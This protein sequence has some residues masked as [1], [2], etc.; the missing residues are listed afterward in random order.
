M[1]AMGI[2]PSTATPPSD[3]RAPDLGI[4]DGLVQLSN[5]VQAVLAEGGPRGARS[6]LAEVGT[7]ADLSLLQGRLLG[8]LRDRQPSMAELARL[9]GLDKSSTT[10]LV[11]RAERRGL[12]RRVEVPE[13]GRSFRV[14]LTEEGGRLAEVLGAEV[15]R[16]VAAITEGLSDTNRHRL[17]LLA[18]RVVIRHAAMHGIDLSMGTD[19]PTHRVVS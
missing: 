13:D 10:G 19:D 18:S 12:V 6:G 5:L 11:D 8:V 2:H 3:G 7:S 4:V 15:A 16:Q 1:P 17:S 9:L 14:V